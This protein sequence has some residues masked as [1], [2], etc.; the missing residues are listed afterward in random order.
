VRLPTPAAIPD[1]PRSV[2][3]Q[4]SA[5][6]PNIDFSVKY[7]AGAFGAKGGEHEASAWKSE[8]VTQLARNDDERNP[9]DRMR[10][11]VAKTAKVGLRTAPVLKSGR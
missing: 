9:N 5:P 11:T 10:V 6:G 1:A 3:A 7:G 2:Q 4:P 8:F